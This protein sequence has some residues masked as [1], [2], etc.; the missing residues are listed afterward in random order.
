MTL[1]LTPRENDLLAVIVAECQ[2]HG[3]AECISKLGE[4]AGMQ[5]PQA[6]RYV[7]KLTAKRLIRKRSNG[8]PLPAWLWLVKR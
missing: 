3:R 5:Q 7:G 1:D 6:H 8:A 4:L 2:A